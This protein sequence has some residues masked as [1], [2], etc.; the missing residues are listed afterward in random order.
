MI[1]GV[2]FAIMQILI[3]YIAYTKL[4]LN[5]YYR[6]ILLQL[7][8]ICFLVSFVFW[9]MDQFFCD[10]MGHINGHAIWHVGTALG[11]LFGLLALI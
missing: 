5:Y 10:H 11:I 3:I 1:F 8:T 7:Y 4:D 2:L 6:W 9:L